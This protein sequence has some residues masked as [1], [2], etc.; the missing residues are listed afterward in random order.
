M[1][2]IPP[3]T[4]ARPRHQS[5]ALVL[6]LLVLAA[7]GLST[8]VAPAPPANAMTTFQSNVLREAKRHQGKPYKWGAVGPYRFDC[9]GY[10]LYVF[11]RLGKKLPHSSSRQY[12]TTR[13][14][15][16]SSKRIGDLIFSR[17]SRGSIYHVGIYAGSNKIWHAPHTGSTVRL[18]TIWNSNYVVGRP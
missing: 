4:P 5:R 17:N 3:I 11:N 1:L 6:A 2:S 8:L 9:S 7:V 18:S 10:T 13:H 12:A 16:R 14:I 15:S